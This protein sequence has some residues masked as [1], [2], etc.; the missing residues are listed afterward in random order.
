MVKEVTNIVSANTNKTV[1][2]K[3]IKKAIAW[4]A[5]M[6][7]IRFLDFGLAAAWAEKNIHDRSKAEG[8]LT[9][10]FAF[11]ELYQTEKNNLGVAIV[12]NHELDFIVDSIEWERFGIEVKT[13]NTT[14]Q[15]LNFFR[16]K[17]FIDHAVKA[18]LTQGGQTEKILTIPIYTVGARFPYKEYLSHT[19]AETEKSDVA[20]NFNPASPTSLFEN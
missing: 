14:S 13:D 16:Q 4:F 17:N 6:H 18:G 3:T 19:P 5:N 10:V 12:S 8:Y 11:N 7:F 1:D 2:N 15:S 9:E 20:T